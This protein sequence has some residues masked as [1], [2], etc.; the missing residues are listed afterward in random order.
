AVEMQLRRAHDWLKDQERYWQRQI[1][2]RQEAVVR[3]K[4]ELEQRKFENRDGKGRGTTEPEIALR[5]AQQR[6]KEAEDKQANCKRWA[7]ELQ[8]A[9]AEYQGPAR[10][11][12]GALETDLKQSVALLDQKLDA[13]ERYLALQAPSAPVLEP[14]GSIADSAAVPPAPSVA[15]PAE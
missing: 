6:L 12:A 11:L 1:R 4:I 14:V 2:E 9:A 5:R 3:A 8:H 10:L 7:P 15:V 13:L